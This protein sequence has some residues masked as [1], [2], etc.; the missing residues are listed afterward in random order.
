MKRRE[1][2]RET[3]LVIRVRFEVSHVSAECLAEAYERVMPRHRRIIRA[4]AP[5]SQPGAGTLGERRAGRSRAC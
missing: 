4:T 2:Q 5:G 3:R 1:E